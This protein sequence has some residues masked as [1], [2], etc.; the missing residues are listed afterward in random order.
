MPDNRTAVI[1]PEGEPG[2]IPQDNLQAAAGRGFKPAVMVTSPEGES[3]FMPRENV[4]KAIKERGFTVGQKTAPSDSSNDYKPS[5]GKWYSGLDDVANGTIG[6][7]K[8]AASMF[9]PRI[10]E[11]ENAAT[12]NPAVRMVRGIVQTGKDA[13]QVPGAIHDINQ[14]PDPTGTYLNVAQDTAS[15]GAGQAL[16]GLAA[17]GVSRSVPI[18]TSPAAET[19]ARIAGKVTKGMI[20]DIPVVR[21]VTKL[22]KYAKDASAETAARRSFPQY[23]KPAPTAG[24]VAPTTTEVAPTGDVASSTHPDAAEFEKTFGQPIDHYVGPDGKF[25]VKDFLDEVVKPKTEPPNAVI[26]KT[27][28]AEGVDLVNKL[29]GKPLAK[30]E[31]QAPAGEARGGSARLA[32]KTQPGRAMDD[33]EAEH[34]KGEASKVISVGPSTMNAMLHWISDTTKEPLT[35]IGH[36]TQRAAF[37]SGGHVVK[38]GNGPLPEEFPSNPW[39]AKR[40]QGKGFKGASGADYHA[41]VEPK[42]NTKGITAEDVRTAQAGLKETGY[43]IE[44]ASPENL[45]RDSKGHL[46]FFDGSVHKA[47]R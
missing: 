23:D 38:I 5:A 39:L 44:D 18:A 37:E 13:L 29:N 24:D 35:S 9:D 2:Y 6:A 10:K 8:G 47:S 46:R 41:S 31:S 34:I 40:V 20:E 43:V 22:G 27:F 25:N 12:A 1:S 15:Q 17:E 36:G 33:A 16:T 30:W 19:T 45:G 21:Q 3:G 42:L 14:S 11:G 32:E 4:A 28:G 26:A 7:V